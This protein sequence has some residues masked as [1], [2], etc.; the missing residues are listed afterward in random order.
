MKKKCKIAFRSVMRHRT[1]QSQ[2]WTSAKTEHF[3]RFLQ[4]LTLDPKCVSYSVLSQTRIYSYGVHLTLG[5]GVQLS[6]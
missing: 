2:F 5:K 3:I 6:H 1:R 4:T